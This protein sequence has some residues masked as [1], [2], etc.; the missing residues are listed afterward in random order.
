MD[1]PPF[2]WD[3]GPQVCFYRFFSV[4]MWKFFFLIFYVDIVTYL[5]I[6]VLSCLALVMCYV[7]WRHVKHSK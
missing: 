4:Q 6:S 3:C 2:Y 7:M 5:D 1:H